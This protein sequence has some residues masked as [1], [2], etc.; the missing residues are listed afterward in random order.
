MLYHHLN[1]G[2][3]GV[4]GI[5]GPVSLE[6]G[7]EMK[8]YRWA[9]NTWPRPPNPLGGAGSKISNLAENHQKRK[10]S[11][12]PSKCAEFRQEFRYNFFFRFWTR[13]DPLLAI[14][15]VLGGRAYIGEPGQKDLAKI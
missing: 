10:K 1:H 13:F 12:I 7:G 14:L 15:L 3:G 11:N 5:N 4:C 9:R 6:I 8:F 2:F